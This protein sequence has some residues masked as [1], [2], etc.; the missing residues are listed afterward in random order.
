MH[1][2]LV[3]LAPMSS[4]SSERAGQ[5]LSELDEWFELSESPVGKP[6]EGFALVE[7]GGHIL[8][9]EGATAEVSARLDQIDPRWRES[10]K[11]ADST[12]S[13]GGS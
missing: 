11:V 13:P 5:L 12:S 6:H 10:L 8:D 9:L 1:S 7:V 3:P 2:H 4:A